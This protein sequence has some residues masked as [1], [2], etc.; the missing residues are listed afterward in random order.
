MNQANSNFRA[1]KITNQW[2]QAIPTQDPEIYVEALVLKQPTTQGLDCSRIQ[3]LRIQ[4]N[5]Q[6]LYWFDRGEQS[7]AIT[8][9]IQNI[10][11]A[12]LSATEQKSLTKTPNP[13]R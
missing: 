6:Y 5:N 2:V 4:K 1:I 7:G 13:I 10:I 9:A 12:L 3:K 8:K 11:Q